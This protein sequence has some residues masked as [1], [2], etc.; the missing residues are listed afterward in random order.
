MKKLLLLT[1]DIAAGKSTFSG[2]LGER[3]G[4][5]VFQKDTLK[6][7]MADTIGWSG[8]EGSK[9]LSDAA[10][11]VM[12]YIFS[13]LAPTGGSLI[14]EANFHTAELEGLHAIAGEHGYQVLTLVLRGE[15]E[16]LY[17]RYLHRANE[18]ERHPVH[19]TTTLDR[20]EDFLETAERIRD[21]RIPGEVLV[22]EAGTFDYQ[23]SPEVLAQ[24][25]AFMK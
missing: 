7:V 10:V 8:R 20:R 4:I 23:K 3:Y 19:L 9:A 21:E 11:G 15:G 22:I 18:E 25:D 24:I 5:P 14:L 16:I 1:G 6:E 13:R 17:R 2:I 12:G